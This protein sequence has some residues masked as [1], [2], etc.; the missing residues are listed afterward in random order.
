MHFTDEE[1]NVTYEDFDG[2]IISTLKLVQISERSTQNAITFPD[3]AK[4]QSTFPVTIGI[5]VLL[6]RSITLISF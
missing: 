6:M 2:G 1:D 5:T 3:P 4:N